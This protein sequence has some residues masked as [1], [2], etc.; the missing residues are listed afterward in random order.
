MSLTVFHKF[1][2][3]TFIHSLLPISQAKRVHNSIIHVVYVQ[4][5]DD[6][7]I[8]GICSFVISLPI[9]TK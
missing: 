7:I 9:L 2:R 3:G 8:A 1:Y 5:M 4:W 6:V